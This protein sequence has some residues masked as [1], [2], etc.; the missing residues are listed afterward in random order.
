MEDYRYVYGPVPSRRMG[1]SL[2]ISPIP[3]KVCNYSC[4]Y[5]Q[6][7]RTTRI[8]NKRED[9]YPVEDILEEA[10]QYLQSDPGLDVITIVGEG[11]PTLYLSIGKLIQGLKE[12]SSKPLAV[13]TNGALL[14]EKGV[15][16]ELLNADIILPSLDAYDEG[17]FKHINRPY[18]ELSFNKV[19]KGIQLFS[20]SFKGQLWL[21][22]MLMKG[23]NDDVESLH[24]LK[25][26]INGI[27]YD[28][29]YINTP[30]R[31]PAEKDIEE[32]TDESLKIAA[33]LLEGIAINLL[34]SEGFS[35]EEAD[36]Y[37]AILSIIKRHP[38]NQ[39]EIKGFLG[40]RGCE[41]TDE[42]FKKLSEDAKVKKIVYKGYETYRGEK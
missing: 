20:H 11:E 9:Y 1:L 35:S 42:M 12:L 40:D 19:Y 13:I 27:R 23:L 21:E 3:Q 22:T 4:L 34:A 38:M 31:P 8:S 28:R 16:D 25:D 36:D 30:V 41:N 33:D 29:L 39:H 15:R 37:R 2:G 26:L 24:K 5:C 17:S 7:G 18:G 14:V 10:R 32:P 6:L